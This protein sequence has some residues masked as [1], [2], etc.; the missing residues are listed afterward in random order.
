MKDKLVKAEGL[1]NSIEI[2][3]ITTH[4]EFSV[5]SGMLKKV[6]SIAKALDKAEKEALEPVQ[7]QVAE[8]KA[9]VKPYKAK[10]KK[11]EADLKASMMSFN[12]ELEKKAKALAAAPV[13][14]EN[15][16]AL[17]KA[18]PQVTEGISYATKISFEAENLDEVPVELL[19]RKLDQ[20]ACRARYDAGEPLPGIRVVESKGIRVRT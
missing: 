11:L 18:E 15:M 6:K 7:E 4:E 12:E 20:K 1:I 14:R 17:A 9:Q 3:E 10:C 8:I 16:D 19:V 5:A 13:T 2:H